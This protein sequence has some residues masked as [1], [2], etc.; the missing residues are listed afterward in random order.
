[1]KHRWI[2]VITT[3][4]GLWASLA[5]SFAQDSAI[6]L[7]MKAQEREVITGD[8]GKREVRLIEPTNVIPGDLIVYTTTYRNNGNEA[9]TD[10]AI[11]NV[12]AKEM[13][14]IAG[15]ADSKGAQLTYSVD[16]GKTFNREENLTVLGA[17]GKPRPATV[18]DYTHIRWKIADIPAG[19]EGSVSYQA[20]VREE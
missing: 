17:N 6:T 15:S 10:V 8:D 9:A 14:Y 2:V 12:I 19:A 4:L 3:A 18:D 1:M 20:Q 16:G 11:T 7:T 5:S 13:R